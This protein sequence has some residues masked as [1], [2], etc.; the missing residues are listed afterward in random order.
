MDDFSGSGV[1]LCTNAFN[2]D[3]LKLLVEAL[4]QN[5]SLKATT[6]KTSFPLGL[7]N[8]FT[9]YISKNQLPLLTNLVKEH[10][11]PSMLYKLNI[12]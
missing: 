10:I 5:F 12:K 4:D 9:L 6:N 2:I 1:K 11:Q 3:E 8:Q 7:E